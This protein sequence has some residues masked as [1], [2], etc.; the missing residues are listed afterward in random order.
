MVLFKYN[1]NTR[2]IDYHN[3]FS[4]GLFK[5]DRRNWI[6]Q[7]TGRLRVGLEPGLLSS[8]TVIVHE[9]LYNEPGKVRS[10]E[11]PMQRDTSTIR[12]SNRRE[13]NGDKPILQPVKGQGKGETRDQGKGSGERVQEESKVP[14]VQTPGEGAVP[15]GVQRLP[16]EEEPMSVPIVV[17]VMLPKTIVQVIDAFVKTGFYLD[18]GEFVRMAV[19]DWIY[20]RMNIVDKVVGGTME[21]ETIKEQTEEDEERQR[22]NEGHFA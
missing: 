4:W 12:G 11:I 2:T 13:E 10:G 17:P 1:R 22:R 9:R 14:P 16:G 18:H 3:C 7:G 5:G 8:D 6:G 19:L 15:A 21:A 20:A